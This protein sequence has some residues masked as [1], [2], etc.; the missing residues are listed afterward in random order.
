MSE[1]NPFAAAIL[2]STQSQRQQSA[3]RSG[4]VR[5]AQDLKKATLQ[6]NDAFEH[7]VESSEAITPAHDD[8]ARHDPKNKR[9]GKRHPSDQA[10][11]SGE[12][13]E[14]LDLTA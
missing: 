8:D 6:G 13:P 11:T 3:E 2:P 7:Q 14:G 9:R 1:V 12:N 5:R 10:N 4:Q